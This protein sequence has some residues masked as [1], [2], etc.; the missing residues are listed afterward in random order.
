M[1]T[2]Q[3][4][5]Q[6]LEKGQEL[7]STTYSFNRGDLVRYAGASGD[8]NP[9]HWNDRFAT[10]VGLPGVIA[11]G[12]LTMGTVVQAVTD[13]AGD[14]TAIVDYQTRFAAMIPVP[15]PEGSNPAE[16]D[17]ASIHVV[18]TVGKLD[19]DA[20]TVRVD[21]TVT[22]GE[23]KVLTKAQAVVALGRTEAAA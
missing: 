11:H 9:I 15:D 18:G 5:L 22:L 14:P 20:G 23:E 16:S 6:S 17:G 21:L 10:E 12:M 4:Q 19:A 8:L 3:V 7:F 1:T 13:W 2:G